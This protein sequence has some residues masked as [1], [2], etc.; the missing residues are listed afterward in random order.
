MA[1]VNKQALANPAGFAPTFTAA[2]A[3]GDTVQAPGPDCY[4]YIKNTSASPVTATFVTPGNLS[5]GDAFPDKALV[6]PATSERVIQIGTEYADAN[7]Q[8]AVTWSATAGVSFAA[9]TG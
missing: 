8:A 1:L 6:V 2:S 3:G 7:N 4:V 5:T 9:F